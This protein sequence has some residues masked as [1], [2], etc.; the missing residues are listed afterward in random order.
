MKKLDKKI[1]LLVLAGLLC[2]CVSSQSYVPAAEKDDPFEGYNRAMFKF[3]SQVDKYVV[4]PVVK[5]YQKITTPTVRKHVGDAFDNLHEPLST[6]NHTLQGD[7]K[8]AGVDVM[9]FAINLTLGLGGFFDVASGWGLK[10]EQSGF[11]KTFAK[12]C[13][14]DGP[15]VVLPIAGPSTL[16][17]AAAYAFDAYGDP[18][19]YAT[20]NDANVRD[21]IRYSYAIANGIVK[22]EKVMALT[23]DI[24]K[25][26]VDAYAS[27]RTMYL[28]NY[29]K[30]NAMCSKIKQD[31]HA[32][33]DFDFDDEDFEDEED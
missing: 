16:R 20:A 17:G 14:A 3:N 9:R 11:D 2:S 15:Y 26:S 5:G 12:W 6:V 25:N 30:I 1:M 21:K 22:R 4:K 8:Q 29:E 13:L 19:Y 28:Q 10:K 32:S 23:D 27:M 7:V 33:Y 18:L 24:E 31:Q